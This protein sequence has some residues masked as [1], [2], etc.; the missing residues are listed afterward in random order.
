MKKEWFK[1]RYQVDGVK[2]REECISDICQ[3]KIKEIIFDTNKHKWN[4]NDSEFGTKLKGHRNVCIVIED[5]NN[6]IFG[7]YISKEIEINKHHFDSK[8]FVF[9]MKRNGEYKMKKYPL[10]EGCYDLKIFLDNHDIL[11]AFGVEDKNNTCYLKDIVI[12]K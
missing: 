12:Y 3:M 5:K 2:E 4:I 7:G 1:E 6:N 8:S 10:N 9:S 11:F